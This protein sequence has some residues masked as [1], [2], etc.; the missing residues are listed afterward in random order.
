MAKQLQALFDAWDKETGGGRDAVRA[1]QICHD[2]IA[3]HPADFAVFDALIANPQTLEGYNPAEPGAAVRDYMVGLIDKAREAIGV[4]RDAGMEDEARKVE[5]HK[6][7]VDVWIMSR[8][9]PQDIGGAASVIVR[10]PN[11]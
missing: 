8:I 3:E 9:E 11:G 4:F 6:L 2:Y 1:R 7:L 5:D 10:I